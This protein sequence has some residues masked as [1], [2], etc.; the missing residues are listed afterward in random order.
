[1]RIDRLKINLQSIV[2]SHN[3]EES[4]A[5]RKM[6]P[7]SKNPLECPKLQPEV[8]RSFTAVMNARK[9]MP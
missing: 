2:K 8:P 5:R 6:S 9:M 3:P 7:K 4:E 1:M